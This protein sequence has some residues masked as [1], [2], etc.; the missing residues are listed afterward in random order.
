MSAP[1]GPRDRRTPLR[2]PSP[3]LY[4]HLG[5]T[6]QEAETEPNGCSKHEVPLMLREK[7]ETAELTL[8]CP[9]C[10]VKAHGGG[11]KQLKI[12]ANAMKKTRDRIIGPAP[13]NVADDAATPTKGF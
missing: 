10:D 5:R 13:A 3:T 9:H 2:R 1:F 7:A 4:R 11:D 6:L 12:V 8:A